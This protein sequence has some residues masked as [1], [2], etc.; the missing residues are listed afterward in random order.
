MKTCTL[1]KTE[2]P[3]IEFLK[4]KDQKDGL[5]FWCKPC[6]KI[7]KA[8]S[9]QKNREKALATMAAYRAENPEKVAAAKKAAYA[10][11][12]DHYKAKHKAQYEENKEAYKA[13][14]RA[15]YEGNREA[16]LE[17]QKV[18]HHSNK[19]HAKIRNAA[20]RKANRA[21]ICAKQIQRQKDNRES[22]NAYQLNYRLTRYKTDPLYALQMT[23]R[24]RILC[25]MA[26]GGYK[27]STKT[28][29]ML[30]C[31]FED[32]KTY[33]E[34]KFLPGMNWENRGLYGWHIDHI[35]PLSSAADR[36]E[37]E[38]LC[39]YTNMQ[40]MWAADNYSKGAKM[41]HELRI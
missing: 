31:S 3:I 29:I 10:K 37:L 33:L 26:K 9:Y 5:H 35:I 13:R 36:D 22:Y 21:E 28:E 15:W 12:P 18:Y 20:Y 23:C 30:G 19:E 39:H 40:P 8:E 17:R 6:L 38:R 2:R 11:K 25:A 14:S 4:R 41:P 16:A 34:S 24:R 32:F 27:K 7:K 1:C